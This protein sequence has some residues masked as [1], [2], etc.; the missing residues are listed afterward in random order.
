LL[1]DA[2]GLREIFALI[3]PV[4]VLAMLLAIRSGVARL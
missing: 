3:V 1:V 4:S 2:A